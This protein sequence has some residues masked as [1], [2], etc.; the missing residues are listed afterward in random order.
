MIV[1]GFPYNTPQAEI[2]KVL[3]E[4]VDDYGVKVQDKF[5]L[6][7]RA[8]LGIMRLSSE[9]PKRNFKT[10]LKEKRFDKQHGG[11][12]LHVGDNVPKDDQ[13]K[14]RAVGKLKKALMEAKKDRS[15][16]QVLRK[17]GEVWTAEGRVAKRR[18]TYLK[19]IGEAEQVKNRFEELVA[20]KRERVKDGLSD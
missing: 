8:S 5:S 4:I 13:Q 6:A 1:T 15:D 16:V 10:K 17:K 3:D 14:E 2:Q 9:T 19:L 20:D 7:L 18:G 11:R 12:D